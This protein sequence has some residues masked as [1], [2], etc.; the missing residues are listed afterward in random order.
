MK[1][2]K[3]QASHE[4][5]WSFRWC[6]FFFDEVYRRKT[7]LMVAMTSRLEQ[8]LR[9][10]E[11]LR[12]NFDRH[13]AARERSDGDD[14]SSVEYIGLRSTEWYFWCHNRGSQWTVL[15]GN[16]D[17]T[18]KTSDDGGAVRRGRRKITKQRSWGSGEYQ[19]R[20]DCKTQE[21]VK[22]SGSN[23]MLEILN[24]CIVSLSNNKIYMSVFIYLSQIIK[25]TWVSLYR[26]QCII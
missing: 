11:D 13:V 19:Q 17:S 6:R 16:G 3:L 10:V 14:S 20:Q 8:Y 2:Q 4:G 21:K 25:Y 18:L 24:E 15:E 12:R 5:A 9:H 22:S 7:I 1:M 26:R 23:T